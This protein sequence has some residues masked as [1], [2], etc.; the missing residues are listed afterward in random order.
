[1]QRYVDGQVR[2]F[3][4]ILGDTWHNGMDQED[5]FHVDCGFTQITT[6]ATTSVTGL[7]HLEGETVG[8]YVDGAVH[9]DATVT[10]GK[11]T[12]DHSGYITTVGYYYNSD[13]ATLPLVAGTPLGSGQGNIKRISRL[14]FWLLDTL[15]LQYGPDYETLTEILE[16]NWGEPQ[17][18]ATPLFT[19][20]T[21]VRFEGNYDRL[22]QV[23]WRAAGPFPATVLA[24]IPHADISEES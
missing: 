5:A 10:N 17:G 12:L 23:Y 2:R 22:G 3:I 19:G 16:R 14:G 1:V 8:V 21:R 15:G 18:A 6:V 24:V 7:W 11:I 4:E 20:M 9:A 13:G